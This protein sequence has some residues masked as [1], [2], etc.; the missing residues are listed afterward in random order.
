MR[1]L[2]HLK[3]RRLPCPLFLSNTDFFNE[4]RKVEILGVWKDAKGII[5]FVIVSKYAVVA[6]K[7][8]SPT[9][10]KCWVRV[11]DSDASR[12]EHVAKAQFPHAS[13]AENAYTIVEST[14]HSLAVDVVLQDK[15]CIGTLFVSNTFVES[16]KDTNW[17]DMGYVGYG[18]L[19]GIIGVG[20]PNVVSNVKDVEGRGA[21]KQLKTMVR[22]CVSD[23]RSS[24][25][26]P[27]RTKDTRRVVNIQVGFSGT[28]KRKC[29]EGDFEKWYARSSK[30]EA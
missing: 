11:I 12:Y 22:R 20:L 24:S 16:L 25:S 9:T 4:D 26:V 23:I 27:H 2:R 1:R 7:D 21:Q 3:R 17:N 29:G 13:S 15:S 10:A 14:T 5:A 18:Q 19:Y 8:F 6:L 28:R 30:T